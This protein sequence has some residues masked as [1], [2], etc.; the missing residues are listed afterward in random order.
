METVNPRIYPAPVV[1][2]PRQSVLR[3]MGYHR[4]KTDL[5]PEQERQIDRWMTEAADLLDLKGVSLRL[6]L[7]F[8]RE[9]VL[10][11]GEQ[12][13]HSP[14]LCRFLRGANEALLMGATGG[15]EFSAFLQELT[16]SGKMGQAVVFDAVAS[17]M[18]DDVLG[19]IM[20]VFRRELM[21]SGLTVMKHRYSAGYG[22]L[23]LEAQG[24]FHRILGMEK[25]GVSLTE[26][27]LLD[28]EKSVTAL[29]GITAGI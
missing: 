7:A 9:G 16:S 14:Q 4:K 27:F 6:P 3:R 19:W 25:L 1:E 21:R 15:R 29:T 8:P 18:V 23:E 26:S 2:L 11:V 5:S 10:L 12:E 24:F 17:E 20:G 13:F 28:P 22:D